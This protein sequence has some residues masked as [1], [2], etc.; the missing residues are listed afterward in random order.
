MKKEPQKIAT[1]KYEMFYKDKMSFEEYQ[2]RAARIS[3]QIQ[4]NKPKN[5]LERIFATEAAM[6]LFFEATHLF[7]LIKEGGEA[8]VT[9]EDVIARYLLPTTQESF[10][11]FGDKNFVTKQI[12]KNYFAQGDAAYTLDVQL[13]NFKEYSHYEITESDIVEFIVMH[14]KGRKSYKTSSQLEF[15]AI[16]KQIAEHIGVNAISEAVFAA[17]ENE[18]LA[19][20]KKVTE[21]NDNVPF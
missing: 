16:T 13:L 7:A 8:C 15:E 9:K 20:A 10:E 14:P 4:E 19:A 5:I 6:M 2:E 18:R 1:K 12:A 11:R 17:W 3:S 21:A